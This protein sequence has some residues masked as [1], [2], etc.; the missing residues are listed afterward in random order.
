MG[1]FDWFSS[2]SGDSL[3]GN[4]FGGDG[5]G[6]GSELVNASLGVGDYLDNEYQA[7]SA[8]P[9]RQVTSSASAMPVAMGSLLPSAMV[10]R[11]LARFPNLLM[12]LQGWRGKGVSLTTSKLSAMLRKFGPNFLV[13]AGILTAGAVTDLLMYN[14]SHRRRRMNPLNPRALSRATR[15]LCSF[16][17]RAA[18]VHSSLAQVARR[19]KRKAFC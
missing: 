10:T 5:G 2:D 18:R 17:R 13:T 3:L 12:A 9:V 15:R 8:T 7:P 11:G 14:A 19:G 4:L 6:L 1:L 16:E